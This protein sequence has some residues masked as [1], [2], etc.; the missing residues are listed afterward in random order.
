MT[1]PFAL[2]PSRSPNR[3]PEMCPS[4]GGLWE[5]G[6]FAVFLGEQVAACDAAG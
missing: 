1:T 4:L 5:E 6:R 3:R 2:T